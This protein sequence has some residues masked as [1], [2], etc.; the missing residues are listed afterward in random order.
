MQKH[1]LE[2]TDPVK[3]DMKHNFDKIKHALPDPTA[4][5][6]VPGFTVDGCALMHCARSRAE[7]EDY[8]TQKVDG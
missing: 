3:P 4:V 5:L 8:L 1:L 2:R 6:P 7:M